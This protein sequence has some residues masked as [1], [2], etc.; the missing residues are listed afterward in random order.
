MPGRDGTGPLSQ[1]PVG[2][3]G[4]G[5]G[6]GGRGRMDGNMAAGPSGYCTCPKC[7]EKIPH[8][9]GMPCSSVTCPKCGSNMVRSQ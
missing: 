3:G 2:G 1:G 7:G 9:Q 5:M 8:Q 4:V 6:R